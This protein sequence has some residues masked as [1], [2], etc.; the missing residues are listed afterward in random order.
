MGLNALLHVALHDFALLTK[1]P[2]PAEFM[3]LSDA[4]D[5]QEWHHIIFLHDAA[6][7]PALESQQDQTSPMQCDLHR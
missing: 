3:L 5:L 7:S 2:L 1:P 4:D 6:N